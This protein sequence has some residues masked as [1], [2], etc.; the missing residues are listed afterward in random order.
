MLDEDQGSRPDNTASNST[1]AGFSKSFGIYP[2]VLKHTAGIAKAYVTR[3]GGG[4]MPSEMDNEWSRLMQDRGKEFGSVTGRPRR[5]GALD[6]PLLRFACRRGGLNSL[7]IT[8]L[9]LLSG[10]HSIPVCVGYLYKSTGLRVPTFATLSSNETLANIKPQFIEVDSW[11]QPIDKCRCYD[12]LPAAAQAY[13]NLIENS[14]GKPVIGVGVGPERDAIIW[15]NTH[16]L[17]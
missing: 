5:V 8:K 14:V 16:P 10:L 11:S 17:F 6:L 13:I 1:Q 12:D 15:R 4:V 3:L 9:D 2:P 7:I